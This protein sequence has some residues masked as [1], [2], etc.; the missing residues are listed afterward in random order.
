MRASAGDRP[1]TTQ[2]SENDD[3]DDSEC[4]RAYVHESSLSFGYRLSAYPERVG[5][6]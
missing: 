2:I 5:N 4:S 3:E 1:A 6:G